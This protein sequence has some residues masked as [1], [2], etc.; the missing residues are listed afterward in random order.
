MAGTAAAVAVLLHHMVA[1]STSMLSGRFEGE[2]VRPVLA[3]S[4]VSAGVTDGEA[5]D[6]DRSFLS[7][8]SNNTEQWK[9]GKKDVFF[10]FLCLSDLD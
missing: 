6:A 7:P 8:K 4:Q 3:R 2:P 10:L 9:D 1:L 5:T